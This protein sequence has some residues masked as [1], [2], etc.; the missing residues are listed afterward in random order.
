[1]VVPALQVRGHL[2]IWHPRVTVSLCPYVTLSLCH[3]S[4]CQAPMGRAMQRLSA[5]PWEAPRWVSVRGASA[6]AAAWL[7]VAEGGPAS[8]TPTSLPGT[9]RPPPA[10]SPCV[11]RPTRCVRSGST[12]TPSTLGSPATPRRG[13]DWPDRE[14]SVSTPS[15]VWRVTGPLLQWSAAPTLATTW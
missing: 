6:C 2:S 8:T 14:L 4:L 1:M 7:G 15:S 13:T 12:S 10:S 5:R 3:V 9:A 11:R